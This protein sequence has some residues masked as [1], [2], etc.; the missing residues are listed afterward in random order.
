[1]SR[2][3][4]SSLIV[5]SIPSC[6]DV[7]ACT[8]FAACLVSANIALSG[9]PV[10]ET[11]SKESFSTPEENAQ[12]TQTGDTL[13]L[14]FEK[15]P[16]REVIQV[17][18]DSAD[19]A[20]HVGDLPTGSFTYAD[21]TTFTPQAAIN[22]VNLFLLPQGYT[23]VRSQ[24]LLSVINLD[25][26]RSE[27]QLDTLA[28]LVQPKDLEALGEYDLVK[29]IFPLGDL[30][31]ADA[32]EELSALNLIVPP[33]EFP[34]T[35]QLMLTETVGKLRSVKTILDSFE[36]RTLDNG[37]VVKNFPL[38]HVDAE[39][40]LIVAR[41]HLGLATGE[42]IGIDVSL[43]ADPRGKNIFVTGVEDK[44]TLIENLITSLDQP[45]E[46]SQPD[47]AN[48]ELRSHTVQ[49][50]N[51]QAVYDVLQTLLAG[52]EIRLSA[53]VE[54][55]TIV[56]LASP[57][58]QQEIADTVAQLAAADSEFEVIPLQKV[59][60]YF[61]ISLIEQMLDLPDVL[62]DEE[63]QAEAPR[64]DADPGSMRLF[65]RGKP[66]QIEQIKKIVSGL[67]SAQTAPAKQDA[68]QLRILP[69]KGKAATQALTL[70][71]RL[72]R[73]ENPIILYPATIA[74]EDA[75]NERIVSEVTP[76]SYDSAPK[77]LP[78]TESPKLLTSDP[79]A[80]GTEIRCQLTPRGL[81][82]QSKDTAALDQLEEQLRTIGGPAN[83]LPAPPTVFYLK[84]TKAN[85]AIRMLAELLDGGAAV[86]EAEAGTLVNGLVSGSADSFLG[87]IVTS[88]EG[89]LTM[90]VETLTVVADTR[91]N[92]LIAQG[93]T[94]EIETI[95]SYLKIIDK[96]NSITDIE[97]YGTSHVIELTYARATEVATAI[98][99]A[100][101][102]RVA[103][104]ASA[105]GQ[106]RP[107]GNAPQQRDND[108]DR[109]DDNDRSNSKAPQ[110]N[111]QKNSGKGQ[112]AQNNEPS[113]TI[114]VHEASNSLIVT[115]PEAIFK[116]VESLANI[117]D[118]RSRKAVRVINLP[119][120]LPAE[121]VQQI[122]S[123]APSFSRSTTGGGSSSRKS[124]R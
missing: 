111:N 106:Q 3:L 70:V 35:N 105:S 103:A 33:V 5:N 76:V 96:D 14:S 61:A 123:S 51:V 49:G 120:A 110:P 117:I 54:A 80:S 50:G 65:V 85:N 77:K 95:E 20:L 89:F 17:L 81:M 7:I 99:E 109:R 102:G 62:D 98:R 59:D 114:A 18:A 36:P 21:K 64:I 10:S 32:A 34:K 9:D 29:C 23:L 101:A 52:E 41:P 13:Q 92:R 45:A 66:H 40:I 118:Q 82:L 122:L 72:W 25:D 104:S 39:E 97:T 100:Y 4:R 112:A 30:D 83:E 119:E 2:Q 108:N 57:Q 68:A 43:S 87:S 75:V 116:E 60:P 63:E 44:V 124:N 22:R 113:F 79:Y 115:A 88:R 91:L 73:A 11:E 53:D 42:M 38:Q 28:R 47:A 27:Q 78:E 69:M 15:A 84:Y 107:P 31:A 90:I 71:A 48:A 86:K 58:I 55:G 19:L 8:L 67:D 56:A 121:S 26:R 37:T 94:D 74:T 16:W 6:R 24:E 93:T 46:N 1:M 12:Q